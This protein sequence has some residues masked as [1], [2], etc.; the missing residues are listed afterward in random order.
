MLKKQKVQHCIPQPWSLLIVLEA[1]AHLVMHL[2][3]SL[4]SRRTS[5]H[6]GIC[7]KLPPAAPGH[8]GIHLA[9][10]ML[11]CRLSSITLSCCNLNGS[12]PALPLV[13]TGLMT[14]RS[15]LNT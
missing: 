2:P 15:T 6:T 3:L 10:S 4:T 12:Q 8:W 13:L 1:L 9:G 11:T 14:S 7:P 5:D